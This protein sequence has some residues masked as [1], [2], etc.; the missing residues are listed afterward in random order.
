MPSPLLPIS[1]V[2]VKLRQAGK[3]ET[4]PLCVYGSK[5]I[6]DG[7]VPSTSLSRC[8]A[9]A[10]ATVAFSDKAQGI[11]VTAE[12]PETCCPGGLAHFG[13]IRLNP[14]IKFF[15]SSGSKDYRNGQAEF[16]R[17]SPE[18][19]EESRRIMGKITPLDR[20]IVIRP[21]VDL[22]NEDPGVRS[23]I[24]F[25]TA[26]QIRNII[27]LVHFRSV[28]PFHNTLVPQGAAC[29]SFVSYAAGMVENSPRDAAFV[30]PSDPTGNNWF[31]QDYLSLAIPIKIARRMADDLECSFIVRRPTVAYPE[32]RL[33]LRT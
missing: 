11:Y 2:G 24:C 29:A 31:P 19:F 18:L 6:P 33:K 4:R 12:M 15:V 3:L 30:G 22:T 7:I 1:E 5:T 26:E 14:S 32:Q 25:G 16:L 9:Q 13:F 8:V 21:C 10:I 27:S 20:Y 17:A 23:I 28:E